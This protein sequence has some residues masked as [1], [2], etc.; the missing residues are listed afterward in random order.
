MNVSHFLTVDVSY[1]GILPEKITWILV[2]GSVKLVGRIENLEDREGFRA[3]LFD[4]NTGY[5]VIRD[6]KEQEYQTKLTKGDYVAIYGSCKIASKLVQFE[7]SNRKVRD[8][9]NVIF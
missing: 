6:Y 3:V 2:V 1:H 4:D 8:L 9:S 5:R 7:I